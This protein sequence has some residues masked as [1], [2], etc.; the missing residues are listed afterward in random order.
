[1]R[2]NK[3]LHLKSRIADREEM[4]FSN[5]NIPIKIAYIEKSK[6]KEISTADNDDCSHV[7]FG[8][9]ALI[10]PGRPSKIISQITTQEQGS[11]D[12]KLNTISV[13]EN[14]SVSESPV[15]VQLH[16]PNILNEA[17]HTNKRKDCNG[18]TLHIDT[19]ID[20]R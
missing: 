11:N 16:I 10:Q 15:Q 17:R 12:E 6:K 18:N 5:D 3:N 8:P 14:K 19:N 9:D 4:V 1:M 7:N 2:I 13:D 20:F